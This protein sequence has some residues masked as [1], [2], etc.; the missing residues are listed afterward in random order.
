MARIEFKK[1]VMRAALVRAGDGNIANAKCEAE[2][3]LY[4]LEPGQRCNCPL[5]HG[6]EFDH[7]L[8]ASNGGDATLNNCLAAC[9]KCHLFKTRTFDTPRAAKTVRQRD[10]DLG[11]KRPSNPMP[12]S[13]DSKWKRRMDGT[14][15]AR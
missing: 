4:D 5:S 3:A 15:V 9:K 11:I 12:G 7:V 1:A 10:K 2:G 6:V 8:A 13:R 14:V